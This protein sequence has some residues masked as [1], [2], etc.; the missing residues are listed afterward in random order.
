MDIKMLKQKWLG[1]KSKRQGK[2]VISTYRAAPPKQDIKRQELLKFVNGQKQYGRFFCY[3]RDKN[4]VIFSKEKGYLYGEHLNHYKNTPSK[5]VYLEKADQNSN[6]ILLV[7]IF[8]GE[9]FYEGKLS[10][11]FQVV[12][13]IKIL[14]NLDEQPMEV[15]CFGLT[16]QDAIFDSLRDQ[17]HIEVLSQPISEH[18]VTNQKWLTHDKGQQSRKRTKLYFI[19]IAI[20]AAGSGYFMNQLHQRHLAEE[21]AMKP[22]I[23]LYAAY[24]RAFYQPKGQLVAKSMHHHATALIQH[25]GAFWQISNINYTNQRLSFIVLPVD[26]HYSQDA[27]L[28]NE[29]K[30]LAMSVDY[31]SDLMTNKTTLLANLLKAP[32]N[33]KPHII[34]PVRPQIMS[35]YKA[36]QTIYGHHLDKAKTQTNNYGVY[37]K[38][39]LKLTFNDMTL[40]QIRQVLS[41]GDW[42]P[43]RVASFEIKRNA[44]N[45]Y[46]FTDNID[47]YGE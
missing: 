32:I 45:S 21:A 33:K 47:F 41:I 34:V 24:K 35:F 22:N 39:T 14:S 17:C 40:Q 1:K 6:D 7:S 3:L 2:Y 9:V 36:I 11:D 42:Y 13:Q 28:A 26:K 44:D 38:L 31:S 46:L 16:E 12:K 19:I 29:S 15:S 18:F 23:D 10:E 43:A 27:L 5:F 37:K 8:N 25:V 4:L 30:A 20:A